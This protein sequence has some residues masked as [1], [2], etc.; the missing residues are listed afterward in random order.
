LPRYKNN[1][2][3]EEGLFVIQIK[4]E[5]EE[6]EQEIQEKAKRGKIKKHFL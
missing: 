1:G 4:G 6:R 2:K 5:R 3:K